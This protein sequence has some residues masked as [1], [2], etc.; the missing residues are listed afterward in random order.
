MNKRGYFLLTL[1]GGL[2]IAHI[3]WLKYDTERFGKRNGSYILTQEAVEQMSKT[4]LDP[5]SE[6]SLKDQKGNVQSLSALKGKPVLLHF[7][8]SWCGPCTEEFPSFLTFAEKAEKDYSLKVI[9][10]SEDESWGDIEGFLK[11]IKMKT[12]PFPIVLDEGGKVAKLYHSS[13]FPETYLIDANGYILQRLVG[14]QNWENPEFYK[15]MR[16]KFSPVNKK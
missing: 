14:A 2:L 10:I 1:F 9:A 5:A 15:V 4:A 8:A 11:K 13:K 12:S 16:A 6:F 3:L 7:W